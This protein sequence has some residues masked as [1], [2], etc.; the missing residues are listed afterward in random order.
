[1]KKTASLPLEAQLELSELVD[2]YDRLEKDAA[3]GS[4]A[5]LPWHRRRRS[6]QW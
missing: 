5:T 4:V 1:M 6:P 3:R 2:S